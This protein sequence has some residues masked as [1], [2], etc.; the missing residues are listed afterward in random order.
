MNPVMMSITNPLS[1]TGQS[2]DSN[3]LLTWWHVD[4]VDKKKNGSLNTLHRY[5]IVIIQVTE[6]KQIC[7]SLFVFGIL[8]AVTCLPG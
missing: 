6:T 3:N 8:H 4:E 2:G 1:Q 5:T 7:L